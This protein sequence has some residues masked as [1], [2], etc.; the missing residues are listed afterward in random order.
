MNKQDL[1]GSL[2]VEAIKSIFNGKSPGIGHRDY[3]IQPTSA[4]NGDGITTGIEWLVQSV[5]SNLERPP[6]QKDIT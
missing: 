1:E 3:Y 5:K 4:L 6:R 2:A